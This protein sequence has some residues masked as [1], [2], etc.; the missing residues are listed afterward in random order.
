MISIRKVSFSYNEKSETR[1]FKDL[2]LEIFPGSFVT[3]I[4]TN[5]AGKSTLMQ[6]LTGIARP[7]IGQIFIDGQMVNAWSEVKR[8]HLIRRV[9]QDPNMGSAGS[10]SVFENLCL[11]RKG[12]KWW[13]FFADRSFRKEMIANLAQ[14]NMGIEHLLDQPMSDLSGGQKQ[15]VALLIATISQPKVLLFDEHT[16]ALDPKAA[17]MVMRETARA[18]SRQHATSIM[19]THN[20]NHAVR[21]GDR[22]I[23]LHQGAIYLDVQGQAKKDLS[24]GDLMD[25]FNELSYQDPT[26]K[27]EL[28]LVVPHEC[29]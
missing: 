27:P 6:L 15:V 25:L 24:T 13:N 19:I 7:K 29:H 1:I 5:G 2:D 12:T 17:E 9:F 18:V 8:S 23:V 26:E 11:A 28:K 3:V 16:A 10:L 14:F 4:G 21:Y 20:M 22:L